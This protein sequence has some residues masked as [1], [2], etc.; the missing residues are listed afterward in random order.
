M[1]LGIVLQDHFKFLLCFQT[2]FSGVKR[3]LRGERRELVPEAVCITGT[4]G[5][6]CLPRF[7]ISKLTA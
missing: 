7:C 4:R 6:L 2:G 3:N 1:Q 5:A